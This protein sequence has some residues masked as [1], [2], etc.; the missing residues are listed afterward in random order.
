ML[1]LRPMLRLCAAGVAKRQMQLL[2]GT[3]V[4]SCMVHCA[5]ARS[6]QLQDRGLASFASATLV[7]NEAGPLPGLGMLKTHQ[8]VWQRIV[9]VV[10]LLFHCGRLFLLGAPLVLTYP[11]A[12]LGNPD[13]ADWWWR[14]ALACGQRSSPGMIKFLQW[15]STRRDMFSRHFCDTFEAFHAQCEVHSWEYTLALLTDAFGVS[16]P[17]LMELDPRP[18]GSGVIAQVY[19]GRWRDSGEQI[20]VK[21]VHPHVAETAALDLE[22]LAIVAGWV[23]YWVPNL[24][25]SVGMHSFAEVM[26]NQLD[27]RVEATNL[28]RFQ[29][30]FASSKTVAFPTPK[31]GFVTSSVLVES[32]VDGDALAL[33]ACDRALAATTVD[34]FLRM[35]FLHNFAHG[36]IHPG[37][38]LVT[39]RG[40]ALLDAGIVNELQPSDFS[41]FVALFHSIASKDG[42]GAGRILLEKSPRHR[43][44]DEPAFCAAIASIV[45]RATSKLSLQE[46]PVGE[47][48]QE[49]LEVCQRHHVALQGRFVSIVVSIGVLE[50]VGRVLDPDLDILS[51]ALPILV[52]AKLRLRL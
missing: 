39:R 13:V 48:L 28:R 19:R 24:S 16:W 17:S 12:R 20:A 35:L 2:G 40:I 36:D 32:F 9:C 30:N 1:P 18:I 8:T 50:A 3:A 14:L 46:V 51:I 45:D 37:N 23:D 33:H 38:I 27:L 29:A 47:L 5:P 4:V 11:I 22:L 31:P 49:V 15:A 43:C 26:W 42:L 34:A 6:L 21:V 10:R 52:Q 25:A 44:A 41:D 7:T